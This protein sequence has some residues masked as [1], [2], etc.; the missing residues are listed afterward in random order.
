[1]RKNIK[2]FIKE[3]KK[4][5]SMIKNPKGYYVFDE[6]GVWLEKL[7]KKQIDNLAG[8]KLT[9]KPVDLSEKSGNKLT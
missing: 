3:L 2:E 1:M 7:I 6:E 5:I 4:N 8:I 9:E